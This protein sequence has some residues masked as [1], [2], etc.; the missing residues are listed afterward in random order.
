MKEPLTTGTVMSKKLTITNRVANRLII[1]SPLLIEFRTEILVAACRHLA[2]L[3]DFEQLKETATFIDAPIGRYYDS[4]ARNER[5]ADPESFDIG[6]LYDKHKPR[7]LLSIAQ[8]LRHCGEA[9]HSLKLA[10]EARDLAVTHKDWFTAGHAQREIAI[11]HSAI[12]DHHAALGI[13]QAAAPDIRSLRNHDLAFATLFADYHNSIAVELNELSRVEEAGRA[14]SVAL[15][16]PFVN[17]YPEWRETEGDIQSHG[18]VDRSTVA[19]SIP[20]DCNVLHMAARAD[21]TPAVAH[22]QPARILDFQRA[23]A[24]VKKTKE[25]EKSPAPA[26]EGS[27]REQELELLKLLLDEELDQQAINCIIGVVQTSP[28]RR[29]LIAQILTLPEEQIEQ[30]IKKMRG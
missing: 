3:K 27:L 4:L 19:V 10:V 14:L 1:V 21:S 2:A 18:R 17:A 22:D 24:M 9:S 25:K 12:G 11:A 29:E 5:G 15:A 23:L 26:P 16:S 30:L 20:I 7:A 8:R 6:A 13:L 28:K